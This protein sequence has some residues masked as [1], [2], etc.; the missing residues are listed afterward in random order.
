[1][2]PS[3]E[4]VPIWFSTRRSRL[5]G[6]GVYIFITRGLM[7]DTAFHAV[8]GDVARL[9]SERRPRGLVV[10]HHHEDHAGNIEL[11]A[12][13]GVPILAAPMTL[14]AAATPAPIGLYRRFVWS[15][16]PL[17]RSPVTPFFADGL[18]LHHTPGHS[19]DH[20]VVWDSERET[21]FAGDLFLA[22][23]VRVARPGE[24][25]RALVDS[26]RRAAALRPKRMFDAHR[27]EVPS[28][29]T[30][31]LAKAAWLE[32]T[33]GRID[34]AID[35]GQSDDAIRGEILGRE[36]W[37]SYVSRGDLC[38]LNF[39]RAVRATRRWPAA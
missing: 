1:M 4:V 24:N 37:V 15:P 7:I 10:T 29:V 21:L 22:V 5:A 19:P 6:Y 17:L 18:E 30:G 36:E 26:L 35:Y 39:V 12:A 38:K 23:K 14:G 3:D 13:S 9:V 27:G 32:E 11:A 33:I 16:M 20:H 28:P 31:L 2:T 34:R 25:P 8:R